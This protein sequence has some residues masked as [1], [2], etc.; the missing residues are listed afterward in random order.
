MARPLMKRIVESFFQ[1]PQPA[2]AK[3]NGINQY[4]TGVGAIV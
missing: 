4:L 1:V 2:P 3:E